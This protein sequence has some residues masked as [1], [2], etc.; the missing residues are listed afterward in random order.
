M[1]VVKTNI[2]ALRGSIDVESSLGEGTTVTLKIPLT[3]AIIEGLLAKVGN[4]CYVLPLSSVEECVEL[5]AEDSGA[6]RG[7]N[8]ANL[9][10]E[11]VP[12]VHLRRHFA[13]HGDRPKIEQIVVTRVGGN[14]VGFVVDEVIGQHQT[15]I[16]NLGY[17]YRDIREISGATILGDGTLALILD[18]SNLIRET[19]ETRSERNTPIH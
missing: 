3:L 11:L 10:G 8:L 15:V 9:R 4:E 13:I 18:V 5:E 12:Y 19:R 7:R 2:E 16:K 14:R 6:S 1:D 17:L